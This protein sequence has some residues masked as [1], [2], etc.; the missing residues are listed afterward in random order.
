MKARANGLEMEP[1]ASPLQEE[2]AQLQREVQAALRGRRTQVTPA[3]QFS[4]VCSPGTRNGALA[5]ALGQVP[6]KTPPRRGPTTGSSLHGKP[7][8]PPD[9]SAG[10]FT[11]R[12]AGLLAEL[13][14]QRQLVDQ[15]RAALKA[16]QLAAQKARAETLKTKKRAARVVEQLNTLRTAFDAER[17]K[18]AQLRSQLDLLTQQVEAEYGKSFLPRLLEKLEGQQQ[19]VQTLKERMDAMKV[20]TAPLLGV[21]IAWASDS[22]A[23][24]RVRAVESAMQQRMRQLEQKIADM[25]A[26]STL[27]AGPVTDKPVSAL[28]VSPSARA[29]ANAAQRA[30]EVAEVNKELDRYAARFHQS[31]S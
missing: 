31:F 27:V 4:S 9:P 29:A 16:E 24:V 23:A 25:D 1:A 8:A 28:R 7:A 20:Q 19:T 11:P 2:G 18:S 3:A 15:T 12:E 17:A 13:Q 26:S 5:A 21:D 22:P 30:L 10:S 14:A 6:A